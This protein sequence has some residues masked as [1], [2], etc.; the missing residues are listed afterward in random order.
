MSKAPKKWTAMNTVHLEKYIATHSAELI[1]TL[2]KNI[3]VGYVRFSKPY[4]FFTGLS[5][6]LKKS[7]SQCKKKFRELE[8][9]LYLEVLG[10]APLDFCLM[11]NIRRQKID[12][13]RPQI[14]VNSH[15]EID[16]LSRKVKSGSVEAAWDAKEDTPEGGALSMELVENGHFQPMSP[17]EIKQRRL[18]LMQLFLE[19]KLSLIIKNKGRP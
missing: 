18:K 6:L 5:K 3:L 16:I 14:P 10:V 19:N 1:S 8:S 13:S 15:E 17:E 9:E 11:E 7:L 2:Y 12:K 4:G